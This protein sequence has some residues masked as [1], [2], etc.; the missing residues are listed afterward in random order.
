MDFKKKFEFIKSKLETTYELGQINKIDFEDKWQHFKNKN[1]KKCLI[2]P[3]TLD[4][5]NHETK[6]YNKRNKQF[7]KKAKELLLNDDFINEIVD[8]AKEFALDKL[9]FGNH[10]DTSIQCIEFSLKNYRGKKK[11]LLQENIDEYTK[12]ESKRP[13]IFYYDPEAHP[14]L[15]FAWKA[16]LEYKTIIFAHQL[17]QK[18]R[19]EGKELSSDY[20]FQIPIN[21]YEKRLQKILKTF[22]L[23]IIWREPIELL[24]TTGYFFTPQ[25]L[26]PVIVERNDAEVSPNIAIYP[27]MQREDLLY[28]WDKIKRIKEKIYGKRRIKSSST[29]LFYELGAKKNKKVKYWE[30][31]DFDE[32]GIEEEKEL[33]E[34]ERIERGIQR[35]KKAGKDQQKLKTEAPKHLKD[36][37]EYASKQEGYFLY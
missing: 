34:I 20:D 21:K 19:K 35:V 25:N 2:E 1:F 3:V 14:L 37:E 24:L 11:E 16:L 7:L 27:E 30:L 29:D 15:V 8:F 18:L 32:L 22:G 28:G 33:K 9:V 10:P 36:L 13:I 5:N 31:V 23:S 12:T 26:C 17:I 4:G 6:Y